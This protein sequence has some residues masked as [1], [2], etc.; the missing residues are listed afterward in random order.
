VSSKG[1]GRNLRAYQKPLAR[2]V[3]SVKSVPGRENWSKEMAALEERSHGL[4]PG[5]SLTGRKRCLAGSELRGPFRD[6]RKGKGLSTE[7]PPSW[8]SEGNSAQLGAPSG[9][10]GVSPGVFFGKSRGILNL[11][12]LNSRS[13]G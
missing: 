4:E 10:G 8:N 12:A 1:V 11:Q 2:K 5:D 6:D 9:Q 7:S 3:K 13:D